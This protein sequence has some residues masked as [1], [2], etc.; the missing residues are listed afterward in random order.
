MDDGLR[1][2]LLRRVDK[3]QAA[4]LARDAD[5]M[6]EADSENLPWLKEL[7]AARGWPGA[8]LVGADG[9]HHAW[10]LVQHVDADPVFQRQ[11]LDLLTEAVAAVTVSCRDCGL[12]TTVGSS[13]LGG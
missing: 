8:S 11:C 5:A 9:A 3:D 7:I 12:E 13:S 1:G 6:T 4:R 2:E 10:L